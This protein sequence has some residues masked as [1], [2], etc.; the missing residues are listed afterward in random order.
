MIDVI[1]VMKEVIWDIIIEDMVIEMGV[2]CIFLKKVDNEVKDIVY[3]IEV[4]ENLIQDNV[5][6]EV[7]TGIKGETNKLVIMDNVVVQ[8]EDVNLIMDYDFF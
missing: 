5:V 1:E 2:F 7:M 6:V 8:R 4:D 3:V